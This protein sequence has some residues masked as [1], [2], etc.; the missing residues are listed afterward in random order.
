MGKLLKDE[1]TAA[2]MATLTDWIDGGRLDALLDLI[3]TTAMRGTDSAL[4]DKAGF[5]LSTA[6]ILSVWHQPLSTIVTAASIG[7]LFKDEITAVRMAT[8]TDWIDGG[9]LDALLDL[10]PTTAMRGTDSALTDKAGFSL[11]AAGILA[12]WHQAL[13]GIV[14][15]ASIGKLFKDEMTPVRMAALTDWIDGGRLD[16][17]LDATK[18]VTDAIPEAGAMTTIAADSARLTAARATAISDLIDGGRLDLLI[19]GIKA[20]TDAIPEAGA[21]TTIGADTARLTA[22]RAGALTD[23]IDGGRLDSLIDAIKVVTDLLSDSANAIKQVSAK[24]GT[25][26]TTTMST[27]LTEPDDAF[28]GGVLMF[29]A[30]TTTVALRLQRT[31]ITDYANTNGVLTFDAV[32]VPPVATDTAVII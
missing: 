22:A 6:G 7:K 25:L 18:A 20:V 12:I 26:T 14:T 31:D 32:T 16:L 10:I 19:D 28:N 11:S 13:S 2:R 1:I 17:L 29:K 23:L 9:R 30:D 27:T 21:L 4:T 5:S 24:A 8:L 3:P 15:A